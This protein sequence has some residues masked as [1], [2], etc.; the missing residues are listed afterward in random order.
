MIKCPNCGAENKTGVKFCTK[1]GMQLSGDDAAKPSANTNGSPQ[2]SERIQVFKKHSL[3]YFEWFTKSLKNPSIV[4]NGNKYFGLVTLLLNSI[5]VAYIFHI[6]GN[7]ILVA[8]VEQAN[9][10]MNTFNRD[11]SSISAIPTG[12]SLYL[13]LLMIVLIYNVIFSLVGFLS[14]KYLIGDNISLSGYLNQLGSYSNGMLVVDIIS[15]I[16]LWITLPTDFSMIESHYGFI[17]VF[18]FAISLLSLIWSIAFIG[19]ILISDGK[20]KMDKIYVA[21]LAEIIVGIVLFIVLKGVYS[22]VAANYSS[23]GSGMLQGILS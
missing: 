3:N 7:K 6:L 13:R 10:L 12:L 8:F 18:I 21:V 20:S 23:I 11:S 19:S 4:K 1:C 17:Y 5:L 16:I 14:K 9:E 22:S 2:A 15:I